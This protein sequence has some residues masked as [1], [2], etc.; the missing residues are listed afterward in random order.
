MAFYSAQG[1]WAKVVK[2]GLRLART[3]RGWLNV[4]GHWTTV[5]GCGSR[6]A[7]T[8]RGY[9]FG[10]RPGEVLA[11]VIGYWIRMDWNLVVEFEWIRNWLR[12]WLLDMELDIDSKQ[13]RTIYSGNMAVDFGYWI[14]NYSKHALLSQGMFWGAKCYPIFWSKLEYQQIGKELWISGLEIRLQWISSKFC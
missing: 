8:Q 3:R 9:G 14:R 4:Q 11:P 7:G 1:H 13:S 2:Y 10:Y 5:V 6:L 12:L